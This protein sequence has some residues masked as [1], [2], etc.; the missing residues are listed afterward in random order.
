MTEVLLEMDFSAHVDNSPTAT[1]CDVNAGRGGLVLCRSQDNE[2]QER[3]QHCSC[4]MSSNN[5]TVVALHDSAINGDCDIE[6]CD[7]ID[8]VTTKRP[9]NLPRNGSMDRRMN[10][11]IRFLKAVGENHDDATTIQTEIHIVDDDD[12]DG[13]IEEVEM[14]IA[15]LEVHREDRVPPP[16]AHRIFDGEIV[17]ATTEDSNF[18]SSFKSRHSQTSNV[19]IFREPPFQMLSLSPDDIQPSPI[20][21]GLDY[22][23][24]GDRGLLR[25]KRGI[26]RG[27]Y[28]QLHRKAWLEVSDSRHRYG[29]NLRLYYRHWE[30]LGHPTNQFFDWLDSKGDAT[31]QP[32]PNLPEC[33]RSTLDS[34]TVLYITDDDVTRRYELHIR[35]HHGNDEGDSEDNGRSRR[36]QIL[37]VEGSPVVTGPDGWIFVL[38]DDR[39]YG[40]RKVTTVCHD[41]KQRFHHSSFFGGK[42]VKGAGI[43]VTDDHGFLTH[44]YPHSGHYRP[45]EQ[46][47][48]RVLCYLF[49]AGVDLSTFCIDMQQLVHVCR[50]KHP[51]HPHRKF[52][53]KEQRNEEKVQKQSSNLQPSIMT[54]MKDVVGGT[55]SDDWNTYAVHV[56]NKKSNS[57]YLQNALDAAYFLSHKASCINNGMFQEIVQ[58]RHLHY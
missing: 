36:G 22:K 11:S 49:S 42:A 8:T 6:K 47:V 46:D 7:S 2:Q 48:Q 25:T 50:H 32:L 9:A 15:L 27:N 30:S 31:G 54:G 44:V 23:G 18:V 52:E 51:P 1:T 45:G 29:K 34:D 17:P 40:S 53:E 19:E 13:S 56:K 57:L 14:D 24:I 21:S 43:I 58:Q 35:A 3:L 33:P 4:S 10:E 26:D 12:G 41:S 28:A 20:S 39:L 37:D 5:S 38:R 16:A 55:T